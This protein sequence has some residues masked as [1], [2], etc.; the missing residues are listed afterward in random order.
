MVLVYI[1]S[2]ATVWSHLKIQRKTF[3]RGISLQPFAENSCEGSS[4]TSYTFLN[5]EQNQ[6]TLNPV[7]KDYFFDLAK[8]TFDSTIDEN[9]SGRHSP[10]SNEEHINNENTPVIWAS[11]IDRPPMSTII[12]SQDVSYG[13][14]SNL[15]VQQKTRHSGFN[16][17]SKVGFLLVQKMT[18]TH[19]GKGM[20]HKLS[21]I[22]I[23]KS[24]K[25]K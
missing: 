4:Q 1:K 8:A 17:T 13:F 19:F 12:Q 21:P 6:A 22:K 2:F 5:R 3:W 20:H 11:S 25:L 14:N 15:R 16:S 18:D 10:I 24:S 9:I 23:Y 7:N